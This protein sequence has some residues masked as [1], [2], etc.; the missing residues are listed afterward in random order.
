MSKPSRLADVATLIFIDGNARAAAAQHN[1]ENPT[2][3]CL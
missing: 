1:A 2:I 3:Y